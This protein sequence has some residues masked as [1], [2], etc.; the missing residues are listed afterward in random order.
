[1]FKYVW[2]IILVLVEVFCWAYSIYDIK[3]AIQDK[4]DYDN[5]IDIFL[6][7]EGFTQFWIILHIAGVFITSLVFYVEA[8]LEGA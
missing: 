2:I 1:M 8:K 4:E 7:L 6:C 5:I 3:L